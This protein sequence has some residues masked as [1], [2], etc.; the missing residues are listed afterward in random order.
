M[1]H[2]CGHTLHI[3]CSCYGSTIYAYPG[4]RVSVFLVYEDFSVLL[5]RVC[6]SKFFVYYFCT[7]PVYV[8]PVPNDA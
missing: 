5:Y 8:A 1:L 2:M 4:T 3:Y 7:E 6:F